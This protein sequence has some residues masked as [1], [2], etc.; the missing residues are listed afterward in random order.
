MTIGI[1][2]ILDLLSDR[3]L[4]PVSSVSSSFT[5]S[6]PRG[7]FVSIPGTSSI[8]RTGVAS[9][10]CLVLHLLHHRGLIAVPSCVTSIASSIFGIR[11]ATWSQLVFD[12]LTHGWLLTV[13]GVAHPVGPGGPVT[14]R[15]S[16]TGAGVVVAR[17][18]SVLHLLTHSGLTAVLG[19]AGSHTG[20][21]P[22]VSSS[23]GGRLVSRWVVVPARC[24]VVSRQLVLDF[25]HHA[26]SLSVVTGVGA[27]H[28]RRG[29]CGP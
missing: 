23:A 17:C 7:A 10:S 16:I 22:T 4:V 25:V 20:L 1:H 26:L 8:L 12:L 29:G 21:V 19:S 28:W 2:S 27:G 24:P 13:A 15:A 6:I 3:R 9:W 14:G 18:Q 5:V 11:V